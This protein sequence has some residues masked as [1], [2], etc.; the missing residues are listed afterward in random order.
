MD[1][2]QSP[3]EHREPVLPATVR[4]VTA[5]GII[6]LVGWVLMFRLTAIRW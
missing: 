1:D 6:I 5:L 3:D 4:F 2:M